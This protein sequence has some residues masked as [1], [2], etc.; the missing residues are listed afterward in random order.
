[1]KTNVVKTIFLLNKIFFMLFLTIGVVTSCSDDDEKQSKGGISVIDVTPIAIGVDAGEKIIEFTAANDWTAALS[2]T[3]WINIDKTTRTGGKGSAKVKFSWDEKTSVEKRDAKLTILVSGEEPFVIN[4]TQMGTSA[5]LNI[6]KTDLDLALNKEIGENGEFRDEIVVISNIEWVIKNKPE[7]INIQSEDGKTPTE[8]PTVIRLFVSANHDSKAFNAPNMTGTF[9]IGLKDDSSMDKTIKASSSSDFNLFEFGNDLP[10]TQIEL[11]V[12]GYDGP[13]VSVNVK[14]DSRW[15]LI[16]SDADWLDIEG[17]NNDIEYD[18]DIENEKSINLSVPIDKYDTGLL[19]T[20]IT[21]K[22]MLTGLERPLKVIFPG[23]GNDYIKLDIFMPQDFKVPASSTKWNGEVINDIDMK[24]EFSLLSSKSYTSFEDMPFKFYFFK[25]NEY[26]YPTIKEEMNWV[27]AAISDAP[28]SRVGL[29]NKKITL[30]FEDRNINP[31]I[32]V[33]DENGYVTHDK[34]YV[35]STALVVVPKTV[36]L[37]D[38][39]EDQ[40]GQ[41]VLK[42]EYR[43]NY[44][45]F[46]QNGVFVPKIE[47]ALPSEI[48]F[49]VAGGEKEFRF[50]KSPSYISPHIKV[51]NI[52]KM[53]VNHEW[54]TYVPGDY[55]GEDRLT[56]IKFVVSENMGN[57]AREEIITI[58]SENLIDEKSVNVCTFVIKQPGKVTKSKK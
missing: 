28:S 56:F 48:N 11:D 20:T 15:T 17:E 5:E 42:G 13:F 18:G 49:E 16:K 31:D 29:T 27:T 47:P 7:W 35:R 1:M 10:I 12:T 21:F 52:E 36:Q 38:M 22:N 40:D 9:I 19:E 14:G 37:D 33:K 58:K 46:S 57:E 4:I 39:F 23:M 25:T 43:D 41:F 55:V 30:T 32:D 24:F 2:T 26:G 53:L 45:I 50:I 6:D 54:I 34:S 8:G 44:Q 51:D 3:S